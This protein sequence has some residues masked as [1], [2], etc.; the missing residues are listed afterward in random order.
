MRNQTQ[1][2]TYVDRLAGDLTGLLALLNGPLA[3]VF[4]GVHLLPFFHP[5]DGSDAGFDPI[6]HTSV[7]HRLGGWGEVAEIGESYDVMAD[8]IV[9]HM[10]AQSA[11]FLD[12]SQNG[13]ESSYDGMFLTYETVYPGGATEQELLAT[14]R[15]RPGLPFSLAT[16]DGRLRLMWTT[17][18]SNQ[19]DIDVS[20]PEARAYLLQ[21][22]DRLAQAGVNL[23]RLDAVG[24]GVK[25]R[26]T[27]SFMIPETFEFIEGLRR[28]CVAR[29]MTMLVEIRGYFRTQ[30]KIAEK[31]DLVYDFALP[32][33]VLDA[34][35]TGDSGP[36]KEWIGI[37]PL[38][39]V[40][41][42]DTHDGIGV[43]DVGADPISGGPALLPPARLDALVERMHSESGGTSRLAT[44]AAASNLDL[45]QVNCT[46]FDALGADPVR[47]QIARLIQVLLPG[48]PQI[49]YVGLLQGR[50]DVELLNR[51]GVGRDIN[52]HY[53]SDGELAAAL[54]DPAVSELLHL[55]RWR[56]N[57]PVFGG[58]F[59]VLETDDS[60]LSMVWTAAER[61]VQVDIDLG[62]LSVHTVVQTGSERTEFSGLEFCR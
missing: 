50:N 14:Y 11:Q 21:I 36:L 45:Y 42:L 29:G 44:G 56:N 51:T 10:S 12:W 17:F 32:A 16:I 5:I 57:E 25:K 39:C 59:S 28:E 15:P 20:H 53:Y 3:G 48:V 6:D 7:D 61:S 22:L 19:I 37:R 34:L 41:V 18:T 62:E 1:L 24:Y 52:R 60:H 40:T 33:L 30:M 9:N 55:Y 8:L 31:V 49:Y 2:I 38:N 46:F 13:S 58:D 47:Y 27:S 23:V 54:E 4:G 43:V 26:G 35:Y